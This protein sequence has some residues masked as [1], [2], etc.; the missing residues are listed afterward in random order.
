MVVIVTKATD[1]WG[2]E[3]QAPCPAFV[4]PHALRKEVSCPSTLRDSSPWP[5][6]RGCQFHI[7]NQKSLKIVRPQWGCNVNKSIFPFWGTEIPASRWPPEASIPPAGFLQADQMPR[8]PAL[9][10]P[11]VNKALLFEQGRL[12][13][14]ASFSGWHNDFLHPLWNIWTQK[15]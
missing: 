12:S 5:L 3:I 2:S 11:R 10:R 4:P 15:R 7:K 1:P 8:T 6:V 9:P 14:S 13:L